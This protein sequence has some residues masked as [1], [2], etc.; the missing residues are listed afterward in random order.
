MALYQ[1][2]SANGKKEI[3]D[4]MGKQGNLKVYGNADFKK[5]DDSEAGVD[6]VLHLEQRN[7]CSIAKWYSGWKK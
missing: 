4:T 7:L 2:Q 3:A 6:S 1:L 5:P